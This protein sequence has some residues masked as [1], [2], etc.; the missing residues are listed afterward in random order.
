MRQAIPVVLTTMLAVS[1]A[2]ADTARTAKM[3]KPAQCGCCDDYARYLEGHGFKLA[4]ESL[5]ERRFDFV[6][7]SAGVPK[8]L[9][10]CHTL[11]I[12]GYVVE[13]LVP[14]GVLNKLLREKPKIKGISLPGM[15]VGAPGMPGRKNGPLVI[16]E[17][18]SAQSKVF[19]TE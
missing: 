17:L 5:P 2:V 8:P 12:D 4:V 18:G 1:P 14:V 11:M 16:Y 15:P 13:G 19:A 6:K 7:R 10:G 3:Y 9:M